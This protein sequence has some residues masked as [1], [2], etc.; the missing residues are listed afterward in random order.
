M[1][2]LL[3]VLA[4]GVGGGELAVCVGDLAAS[5]ADAVVNA[6]N[7]E[8]AGGGGVDGALHRAAGPGLLAAGQAWVAANGPLP[9]GGAV[10]TPG[11]GLAARWVVHTVGPVWRGGGHGEDALLARAYRSCLL[12]ARDLGA[13]RVD[14][15][16]VSCGAYGFP[17]ARAAALG[18]AELARGLA[19]GL[20][21]RARMVIFSADAAE[22]WA[23]AAREH[24]AGPGR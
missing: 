22:T 15:P 8:L 11:F 1:D 4:L 19:G 3:T 9:V 12:A 24:L 2:T 5:R 14:F 18:V 16:A 17:V 10:A 7:P 6:A 20:V 21:K 23:R 13:A